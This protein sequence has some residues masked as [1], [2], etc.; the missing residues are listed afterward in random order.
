M[1][2]RARAAAA[3]SDFAALD[4]SLGVH[5]QHELPAPLRDDGLLRDQQSENV[6]F[7]QRDGQEHAGKQVA[8]IIGQ[9]SPHGD[10]AADRVDPGI[11]GRHPSGKAGR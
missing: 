1:N 6:F 7:Q 10:R 11:Y 8:V 3:R 2:A 9:Q 4:H 5:D